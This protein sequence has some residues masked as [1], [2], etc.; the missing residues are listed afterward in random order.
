MFSFP[1][2]GDNNDDVDNDGDGGG[3]NNGN[4]DG[5]GGDDGDD[6]RY[7]KIPLHLFGALLS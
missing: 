2:H 3:D 1:A 4:D 7:N 6:G 5:S